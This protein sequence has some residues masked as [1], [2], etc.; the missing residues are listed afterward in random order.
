MIKAMN[1]SSTNIFKIVQ[2]RPTLLLPHNMKLH[3][4][5]QLAYLDLT[6]THFIGQEH[7]QFDCE[8]LKNCHR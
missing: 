8:Y 6:L 7:T 4:G 2:I 3:K 5:F 1:I